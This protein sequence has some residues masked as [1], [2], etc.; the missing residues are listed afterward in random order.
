MTYRVRTIAIAVALALVAAILVSLYVAGV[1]RRTDAAAE[2]VE[3]YVAQ[4]D[5]PAG[6]AGEDLVKKG[7]LAKA[8][9][10]RERVV[11][12]TISQPDQLSGLVSKQLVLTGEQV[13]TRRF[14]TPAERGVRA[15]LKGTLRAVQVPG[16]PNQLLAGTLR[17]G[18]R[19][20]VIG[21]IKIPG[22]QNDERFT[23]IVLRDIEVL[24]APQVQKGST[25]VASGPQ[26]DVF[27][28]LAVSDTQVQKLFYVMKNSDWTFQLRPPASADDSP[29]TVETADTILR[30][31]LRGAQLTSIGG[32]R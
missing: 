19:V 28:L 30:D 4:K 20:D 1:K 6:T 11:G 27:A 13:T 7:M 15:E 26:S 21:N 14:S 3:V 24:R 8:E 5:I 12:G 18:D 2:I 31:G 22:T 10:P 9:I 16:D 23:R 17:A 32:S 25:K 29:E